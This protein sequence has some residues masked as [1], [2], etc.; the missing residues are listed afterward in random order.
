MSRTETVPSREKTLQGRGMEPWSN[1]SPNVAGDAEWRK[2]SGDRS[3]EGR[4][5]GKLGS[6]D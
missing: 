6:I 4:F 2:G 1:R 3:G 5:Q